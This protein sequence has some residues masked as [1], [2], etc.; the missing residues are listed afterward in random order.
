MENNSNNDDDIL[1]IK[2]SY[3]ERI[4]INSVNPSIVIPIYNLEKN[5]A[6][7]IFI[8]AWV[9]TIEKYNRKESDLYYN[10]IN[11]YNNSNK[12]AFKLNINNALIN[13]TRDAIRNNLPIEEK[14]N[15]V[16]CMSNPCKYKTRVKLAK[17][18]MER[19]KNETYVNLYVV[20]LAYDC[21][22]IFEITDSDNTHHLQL[23][24]K[25]PL[26]HKENMINV[27][28]LKL[29]PSD[30]KAVAWIDA[31]I[32]FDNEWWALDTLKLLN[33]SF[34]VLQ[35]FNIFIHMKKDKNAMGINSGFGYKYTKNDPFC[36]DGSTPN[37]W[38][39]GFAW[40]C[41]RKAFEQMKGIHQL[42]I[43]GAGDYIFAICLKEEKLEDALNKINDISCKNV[44]IDFFYRCRGLRLGYTPGVIRHY[45]HGSIENRHYIDRYQIFAKHK[46]RPEIHITY[47][48][49]GILIPTDEFSEEFKE[50]IYNYFK[51]RKEDSN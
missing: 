21:N 16:I 34:D 19:M 13:I 39:P 24:T 8:H 3:Y 38:H 9:N 28:I 2:N 37:F 40:A 14:L 31:D 36:F 45:Y 20:E 4:G 23:R 1:N 48:K 18:F 25:T 30:W 49:D 32:D 5:I 29:L 7:C 11:N 15:V 51:S 12:Q 35:L 44:N 43:L 46:Y 17:E 10:T 26:W 42:N 41:T 33:G 22:P 50:D 6:N 27:G 47:D